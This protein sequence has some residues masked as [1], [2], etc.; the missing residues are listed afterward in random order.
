MALVQSAAHAGAVSGEPRAAALA[1]RIA[2][3]EVL[4]VLF[5]TLPLALAVGMTIAQSPI[6]RFVGWLG[7]P[8]VFAGA[9][10]LALVS[11]LGTGASVTVAV[12]ASLV[13]NA[14]FAVYGAA[15]GPLFERQPRWFR[16]IGPH[17]LVDQS[18]AL[19][20]ARPERDDPDW[21]R[22]YYL[23]SSIALATMWL[24]GVAFGIMLEPV[25][26]RDWPIGV[27]GPLMVA[28]LL[29]T[30]LRS[31]RAFAVAGAAIL[32]AVATTPLVGATGIIIAGAVGVVVGRIPPWLPGSRAGGSP[33]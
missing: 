29:G 32:A 25:L 5:A 3:R 17:F 16:W 21:M 4:P 12:A 10:H 26:P 8:L 18:F 27:A 15:L 24:T 11:S 7:A 1:R 31:P 20:A 30:S 19:I 23:T 2:I 28:S 22:A 9:S 6:D 14:R 33:R 13:V